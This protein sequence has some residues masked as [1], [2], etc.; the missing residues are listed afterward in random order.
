VSAAG[1]PAVQSLAPSTPRLVTVSG[2]GTAYGAP[3]VAYV[4]VGVEA[5]DADAAAA[6]ADTTER[7]TAVMDAV[8]AAGIAPEDIRTVNYQMWLE[9]DAEPRPEPTTSSGTVTTTSTVERYHV[10]NQVRLTVRDLEALGT[11]L[12]DALSTGANSAADISFAVEDPTALQREARDAA[13]ANAKAKADQL[14]S[15]LG[16]TIGSVYAISEYSS[17]PQP[18]YAARDVYGTAASNAVPVSS[19][20]LS[21]SVDIQVS[22]E[23]AE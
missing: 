23:I 18:V 7:M 1:A 15:G 12:Q 10:L 17:G 3:D 4:T 14:A 22:F 2:S 21:V 5:R 13:I 9:T 8:T 19:G 16:A 6:V 11:V 20:T